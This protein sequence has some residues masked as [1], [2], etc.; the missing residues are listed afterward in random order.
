[1]GRPV[2][3]ERGV[4]SIAPMVVLVVLAGAVAA[5]LF[6]GKEEVDLGKLTNATTH[7]TVAEAP[8]DPKP[9][10]ATDGLV[11][12]PLQETPVYAAP[13]SDP[14][15][16]IGPRQFGPT[17]LPVIDTAEGWVRVLLPSRPNRSTGWLPDRDLQRAYSPYVVKV[18]T[19]SRTLELLHRGRTQGSWRVAVG[20]RKTPTPTG[21]TFV[22]GSITDD[23]QRYSPV[24]LPLGSHSP[25]LDTY[26]GGPGTVALHG[27][28]RPNVFGSAVS[29]GCIR[30]PA[31][32][33]ERL[34]RVPLGTLVVI[35]NK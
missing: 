20:T 30:V 7:A 25:T 19:A 15:A 35:D 26:G 24:I 2:T 14:F 33:L 29:H 34:R 10:A 22:L 5:S 13:D 32:A 16:K 8:L 18:H 17:W 11:V 6:S 1:M 4:G 31:G 9:F 23:K 27:W 28:P 3:G 12:H 21:R